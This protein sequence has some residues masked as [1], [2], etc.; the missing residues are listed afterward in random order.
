MD[1]G[2]LAGF[3]D[4]ANGLLWGFLLI[5]LLVGI[6]ILFALRSAFV[7]IRHFGHTCGVMRQSFAAEHG[8]TLPL[9]GVALGVTNDYDEQ[10]ARG[11]R[12]VCDEAR[13][14][15]LRGRIADDVW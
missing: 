4:G 3:V 9:S 11:V 13:F 5:H 6:G 10:L 2:A 14:P 1:G 7:Q 12:P 15:E 8:G